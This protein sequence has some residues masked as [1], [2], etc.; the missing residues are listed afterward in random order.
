[1]LKHNVTAG[2]PAYLWLTASLTGLLL[3][4][5][6]LVLIFFP[7]FNVTQVIVSGGAC[8]VLALIFKPTSGL[9][10]LLVIGPVW[11]LVFLIV[12]K[13]GLTNIGNG[14]GTGHAV[15]LALIPLAA[16]V[17]QFLATRSRR[18]QTD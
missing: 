1:M 3:V 6:C 5:V 10:L 13:V 16:W 18:R 14:I 7:L 15:S 8:F 4:P 11:F 12:L 17:G 2:S 9:W